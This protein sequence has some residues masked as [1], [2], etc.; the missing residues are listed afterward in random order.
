MLWAGFGPIILQVLPILDPPP[1]HI[2]IAR[3][4]AIH[5]GLASFLAIRILNAALQYHIAVLQY[6]ATPQQYFSIPQQC[7]RNVF[8]R[9]AFFGFIASTSPFLFLN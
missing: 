8:L 5:I 6:I 4:F 3:L 7:R 1:M 9:R 2:G